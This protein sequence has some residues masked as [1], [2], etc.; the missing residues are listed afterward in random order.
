MDVC[1]VRRNSF[2]HFFLLLA[3]NPVQNTTGYSKAG[4]YCGELE[5]IGERSYMDKHLRSLPGT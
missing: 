3:A 5:V 4:G 1:A 2:A